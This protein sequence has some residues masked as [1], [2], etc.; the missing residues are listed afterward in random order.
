MAQLSDYIRLG[1]RAS[2]KTLTLTDDGCVVT[3][4]LAKL[5]RLKIG[6]TLTFSDENKQEHTATVAGITERYTGHFIFM[7][8]ACYE[9]VF[10]TRY[11]ANA[12]LV[13]L[14]DRSADN[15]KLQVSRYLLRWAASKVS[16]RIRR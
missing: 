12:H 10:L 4:R 1:Q 13:T 5:L 7:D 8:R 2:G 9:L 3:E 11:L 16:C 14:V 6:D 15:A